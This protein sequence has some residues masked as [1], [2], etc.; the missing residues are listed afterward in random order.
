M[1]PNKPNLPVMENSTTAPETTTQAGSNGVTPSPIG[2]VDG[3]ELPS[4]ADFYR[5]RNILITGGTGFMGKVLVEKLLRS[6]PA[7]GKIYLL[8][9]PNDKDDVKSRLQNLLKSEVNIRLQNMTIYYQNS[10]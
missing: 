9:R 6:C 7:V 4:V 1:P 5:D 3:T 2:L 8:I 10:T